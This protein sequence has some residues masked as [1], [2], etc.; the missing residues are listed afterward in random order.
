MHRTEY[1]S[2]QFFQKDK[3]QQSL[4][5]MSIAVILIAAVPAA[6]VVAVAYYTKRRSVTVLSALAL[7][8][9]GLATGSPVYAALDVGAVILATVLVWPELKAAAEQRREIRKQAKHSKNSNDSYTPLHEVPD[10]KHQS[11]GTRPLLT[12]SIPKSAERRQPPLEHKNKNFDIYEIEPAAFNNEN[13]SSFATFD[14][15]K[16]W[17]VRNPGRTFTRNP[18][19]TGFAPSKNSSPK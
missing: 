5:N 16:A 3:P 8:A 10:L 15:A 19:G 17:A 4:Q 1:L 6:A 18:N 11:H 7:S 2:L 9:L 14:E 12:T 13:P